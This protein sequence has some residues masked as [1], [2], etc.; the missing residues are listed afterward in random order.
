MTY[1]LNEW[2][3]LWGRPEVL[4]SG[5]ELLNASG[6]TLGHYL[7]R[8]YDGDYGEYGKDDPVGAAQP[9]MTMEEFAETVSKIYASSPD[10]DH[11]IL[12][13]E[14][15]LSGSPSRNAA[16]I[17]REAKRRFCAAFPIAGRFLYFS[18]NE[19]GRTI[20]CDYDDR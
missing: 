8:I 19:R 15:T 2:A 12:L 20:V 18:I 10:P 7:E 4:E 11:D 9:P 5:Q 3:R 13:L 14:S 6:N 17:N 16:Q 1:S